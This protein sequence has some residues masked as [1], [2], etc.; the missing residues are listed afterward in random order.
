[1]RQDSP[2]QVTT[3]ERYVKNLRFACR[4]RGARLVPWFAILTAVALARPV[5]DALAAGRDKDG[6]KDKDQKEIVIKTP[7]GGFDAQATAD[8]RGLGLPVYPGARLLKDKE[9]GPVHADLQFSGKPS[10]KFVVGK[11]VTPDS[12]EKVRAFYQKKLE[13][14]VTKFTEKADDGSTVFEIERKL[15]Q[16]YVALKSNGSMTEIDL[17]HLEGVESDGTI[18]R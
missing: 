13:K 15:D 16:K 6:D 3:E 2:G 14:Q 11:F 18:R 7:W 17:V 10:M 4:L 9:S 1:M 5:G 12:R 8:A